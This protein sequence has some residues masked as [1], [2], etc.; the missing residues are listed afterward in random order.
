MAPQ[1]GVSTGEPEMDRAMGLHD[2]AVAPIAVRIVC[3]HDVLRMELIGVAPHAEVSGCS[4][5]CLHA[6]LTSRLTLLASLLSGAMGSTDSHGEPSGDA[7]AS[8]TARQRT[9][10]AYM[11]EGMTNRQIAARIAFSQSTVRLESMAIYRYFGVHSRGEAVKVARAT[12][13]IPHE[14]VARGA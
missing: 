9:I 14:Q 2:D 10:L 3:T 7:P 8:L 6:E 4:A 13:E 1:Q 12:G 11:A 5:E